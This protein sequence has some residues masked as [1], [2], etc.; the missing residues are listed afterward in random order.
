MTDI[1]SISLIHRDTRISQRTH[2]VRFSRD[3][4]VAVSLRFTVNEYEG[5]CYQDIL[6]ADIHRLNR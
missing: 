5:R 6:V 1:A 3:E 2:T 4:L